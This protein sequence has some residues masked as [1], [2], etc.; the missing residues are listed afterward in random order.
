MTRSIDDSLLS[1]RLC[2]ELL[3]AA[4][5]RQL[6]L[7][8]GFPISGSSKE[9]L[10][11]S[12][13]VRL[14]DVRGV[15]EA[16]STLERIWCKVL[17]LVA[18]SSEPLGMHFVARVVE[19][20]TDDWTLDH[21]ALWRKVVSGLLAK[22]VAL[23]T[24]DSR[25]GRAKSRFARFQLVLPEA[26]RPALPH[27]PIRAETVSASAM[28]S[29][30]LD[31]LLEAALRS[32]VE[33]HAASSPSKPSTLVERVAAQF[34][35]KAGVI[36][37]RGIQHP[38]GDRI[39]R[40]VLDA[41]HEGLPRRRRYDDHLLGPLLLHILGSLPPATACT[42]SVLAAELVGLG[43][44]ATPEEAMTF[45]DEGHVAGFLARWDRP[46]SEPLFRATE[47]VPHP[48][49]TSLELGPARTGGCVVLPGTALLPVLE[50][51]AVAHAAIENGELR[52]EPDPIR[53][54]RAW[55][56]LP[57]E[58]VTR[59]RTASTAF[60]QTARLI[61][62]RE[63]QIIAHRGLSVLRVDDAGLRAL[64]CQRFADD[65]RSLGR[66]YLACVSGKL[67]QLLGFAKKEGF[68]ARRM[69]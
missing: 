3:T 26:F 49:R 18:A 65:V 1:E 56:D 50:L 52:F 16:M 69:S 8:R 60:D 44:E 36:G 28:T 9:A 14:L 2:S 53:L 39:R 21:R 37:L 35:Y 46:K 43:F 6:C 30:A 22:G 20:S 10:S 47:T 63:G 61:A 68:V 23:A 24:E 48:V 34:E 59:L 54:G 57:P 31:D 51:G 19:P 62:E 67:D 15:S 25:P 29:R 58:F 38:N 4:E 66:G 5:L 32:F 55:R 27:Y 42:P 11:R 40:M 13:R 41:W 17:H 7:A 12:A 64:L 45:C 33:H